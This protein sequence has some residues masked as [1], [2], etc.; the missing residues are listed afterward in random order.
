MVNGSLW[1]TAPTNFH[2]SE[3]CQ[4]SS[5]YSFSQMHTHLYVHFHSQLGTL[6]SDLCKLINMHVNMY[7]IYA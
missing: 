3:L 5:K 6:I 1:Y 4:I 2:V 7:K